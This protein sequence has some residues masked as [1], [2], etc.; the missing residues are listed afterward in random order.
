MYDARNDL[1]LGRYTSIPKGPDC[2]KVQGWIRGCKLLRIIIIIKSH[3]VRSLK[4]IMGYNK[5]CA[6]FNRE[7][8]HFKSV[9]HHCTAVKK[10]KGAAGLKFLN[11]L[12]PYINTPE[13]WFQL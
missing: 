5:R 7:H 9:S 11:Y 3:F 1:V 8:S 6:A 10:K 13:F 2:D 4:N 12:I